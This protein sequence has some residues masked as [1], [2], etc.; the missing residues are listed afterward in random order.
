MA[1]AADVE[2]SSQSCGSKAKAPAH[3]AECPWMQRGSYYLSLCL[4]CLLSSALQRPPQRLLEI[5]GLLLNWMFNFR[6]EQRFEEVRK[7]SKSVQT[8]MCECRWW[9][10]RVCIFKRLH[11]MYFAHTYEH[12]KCASVKFSERLKT[13]RFNLVVIFKTLMVFL[14]FCSPIGFNKGNNW[15]IGFH[16]RGYFKKNTRFPWYCVLSV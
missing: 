12:P 16:L 14:L 1:P 6:K 8:C 10:L 15:V 2:G 11:S 5:Q 7:T 9:N 3:R 4:L 13:D